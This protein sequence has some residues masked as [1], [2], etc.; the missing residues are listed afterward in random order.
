[1]LYGEVYG[2]FIE[3]VLEGK[4]SPEDIDLYVE[5]WWHSSV[6]DVELYDYLGMTWVE[7]STWARNPNKLEEIINNRKGRGD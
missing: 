2:N 6:F 5:E 7:Y 1:M 4:V 3:L